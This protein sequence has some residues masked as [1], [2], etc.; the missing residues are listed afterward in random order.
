M[1]LAILFSCAGDEARS[2]R[3]GDEV[4]VGSEC[5]DVSTEP[6][7][8]G[9]HELD[10]GFPTSGDTGQEATENFLADPGFE[11][12]LFTD[13]WDPAATPPG[14]T[15]TGSPQWLRTGEGL[16]S[17][18][19]HGGDAVVALEGGDALQQSV[20]RLLTFDGRY[21]VRAWTRADAPTDAE[22]AIAFLDASRAVLAETVAPITAWPEWR[23]H[24]LGVQGPE[25]LQHIAASIRG[26]AGAAWFDDVRLEIASADRLTFDLGAAGPVFDGFG[27]QVS[28]G[29]SAFVAETM[30]ALG[31]RFVRVAVDDAKDSD[32]VATRAATGKAPW[33]VTSNA[34]EEADAWTSRVQALDALGIH[35]EAIELLDDPSVVDEATYATLVEATRSALDT[36]KLGDV[37]IAGPGTP[38]EGHEPREIGRAHV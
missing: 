3:C 38:L 17:G 26:V 11:E 12:G 4:L 18:D 19:A 14:W 33:L 13:P 24:S 30:E 25:D 9:A 8:S 35:P 21:V 2:R 28:P 1:M 6:W 36:A 27:V 16:V 15:A 34:L 29:D 10:G 7:D 32:L 31:V 20:E 22:L 23:V 37:A 5:Q